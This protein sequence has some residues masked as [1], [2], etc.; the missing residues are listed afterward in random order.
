MGFVSAGPR[1]WPIPPD[2][3]NGVTEAL[4]WGT[5]VMTAS[6]TAVSDHVAYTGAPDRS[7]SFDV[8]AHGDAR[9]LADMLLAGHSGKWLLPIWP[10]VQWLAVAPTHGDTAI[11]CVT[12]GYDFVAGGQALLWRAPNVWAVLDIDTVGPTGLALS[13]ALA[14]DWPAGTRLYPLRRARIRD[15]AEEVL[16][17]DEF[18]RRRLAFDIDEPCD[19]PA[20][21]DPTTYLAHP[22]LDARPDES[23]DGSAAF[24]RLRQSVQYDGAAPLVYDVP[25]QALR[26][27]RTAF[28]LFGRARH[29][30]LRS[31]LYTL[32]GRAMPLW[33]PS[34]AADLRAAATI[35]GGSTSLVV[36]WAGYTQFGLA[37]PNRRDLRI[38]L[39]D[40]TVLYRRITAAVE[41]GDTETLTLSS[42]LDAGSITPERIRQISFMALATLASDSVEIEHKTDQ[43]GTAAL[44]LGWKAVVPDV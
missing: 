42:A 10:D 28:K 14:D 43:D 18:S 16:Q 2:W 17:S 8:A 41:A 11:I 33:L 5:N 31:L 24:D 25:D 3:T 29:T 20:L 6:G 7:L 19:W 1:I 35:S 4:A 40:G 15:G 36:D 26:T 34:F 30:W 27:Q 37:R 9:Q 32:R 39:T 13:A 22:V 38:E 12:D 21:A 23:E 44:A